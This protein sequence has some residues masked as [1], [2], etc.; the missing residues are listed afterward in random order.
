MSFISSFK[1]GIYRQ[2]KSWLKRD[3]AENPI[4]FTA[5]GADPSPGFWE[6]ITIRP[7]CVTDSLKF[8]HCEFEYAGSQDSMLE[9][10]SEGTSIGDC[11]YTHIGVSDQV[12]RFYQIIAI[13]NI[14]RW[15]H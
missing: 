15:S 6:G 14:R 2:A 9:V 11:S 7:Y 12:R 13:D 10:N 1:I 3:T 4:L 5:D 8:E